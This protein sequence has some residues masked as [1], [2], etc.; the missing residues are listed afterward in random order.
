MLVHSQRKIFYVTVAFILWLVPSIGL[1]HKYLGNAGALAA[2]PFFLLLVLAIKMLQRELGP[3]RASAG[4][5][6]LVRSRYVFL[7]YFIRSLKV[8]YLDQ[9]PTEMTP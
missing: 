3:C 1:I 5:G 9:V 2:F 6:Q 4:S 8:A 7:L